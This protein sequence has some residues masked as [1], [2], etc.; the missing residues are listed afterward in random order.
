[1]SGENASPKR[2]E[3]TENFGDRSDLHDKIRGISETV[4]NGLTFKDVPITSNKSTVSRS[5]NR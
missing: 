5:L 4:A 3:L 1:M 2:S